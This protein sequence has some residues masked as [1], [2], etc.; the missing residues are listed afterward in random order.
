[1]GEVSSSIQKL[2]FRFW[3]VLYRPIYTSEVS[4]DG[5]GEGDG[6]VRHLRASVNQREVSGEGDGRKRKHSV[7]RPSPF[8][9][10]FPDLHSRVQV[11]YVSVSAYFTSVNWP[12]EIVYISDSRLKL[13]KY[14]WFTCIL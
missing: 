9:S 1:V 2:S 4:G 12:H 11:S 8:P 6:D 3:P 10:P 7:L 13:I 5:E 14:F